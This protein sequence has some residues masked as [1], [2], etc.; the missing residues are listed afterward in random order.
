MTVKQPEGKLL[1]QPK[2]DLRLLGKL[3]MK[4]EIPPALH[5]TGSDWGGSVGGDG[6]FTA[7]RGRLMKSCCCC[8]SELSSEKPPPLIHLLPLVLC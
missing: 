8:P 5:Q 6:D 2:K 3:Q 7:L 4:A 1:F